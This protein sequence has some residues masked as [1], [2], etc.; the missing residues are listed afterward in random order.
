M[1]R[2]VASPVARLNQDPMSHPS[3]RSSYLTV[4]LR[5]SLLLFVGLSTAVILYTTKRNVAAAQGLA[6]KALLSTAFALGSSAET[7]L[8]RGGDEAMKTIREIFSDRVVAYARITTL[9]GEILFHTNPRL[10]G[11]RLDPEQVVLARPQGTGAFTS[12]RVL[13]GTG[14]QGY[15]FHEMIH[16][17]DGA[18]LLLTL[19]LH[20][21]P[22]DRIVADARRTWWPVGGVVTLL[23]FTGILS[24]RVLSRQ[25][26]LREEMERR[27]RLAL[28]GQMT[29]VLAHE[30]RN[31]LGGL[32]GYA[33]WV[34][35][36]LD[37]ADPRKAALS[38]VLEGVM[39]IEALVQD[40]LL[41]SRE[42]SY[43]I[44]CLDPV[45][46]IEQAIASTT[47]GWKGEVHLETETKSP[48]LADR[49]KLLRVLSNG[50]R[51][52]L[53][54]MEEEAGR[55]EI[56]VRAKGSRVF[57]RIEDAGPG[58]PEGDLVRVFTPFF[59]TKPQGTGL[60]LAYSKKVMEEMGGRIS[61]TNRRKT[62]G[63]VLT[64]ELPA[65]GSAR[66]G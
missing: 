25:F 53:E 24:E 57:I 48:V 7:A 17:P 62:H 6:D 10:T 9:D 66:D 30:I 34:D 40:L 45:E 23:W 54:A 52:A 15:E 44:E 39:R 31:A 47:S 64:I 49:E 42:E 29:A 60:G 22:M 20:T 59:T 2:G 13:L 56:S 38:F 51:N 37:Q 61:L 16:R 5:V 4:V 18:T 63:A 27:T 26:R 11:T 8:T 14:L 28:I 12:R 35:E 32:K 36:K 21:T 65:G 43:R 33:Q 50:L 46:L 1:Y 3:V 58:I 19:V 41:Y 55:I